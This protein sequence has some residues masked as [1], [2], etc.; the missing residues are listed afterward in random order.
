MYFILIKCLHETVIYIT[1]FDRFIKIYR[2]NEFK[3]MIAG[4]VTTGC[5]KKVKSTYIPENCEKRFCKSNANVFTENL[6]CVNCFQWLQQK[7]LKCMSSYVGILLKFISPHWL[8]LKNEINIKIVI[9]LVTVQNNRSSVQICF[10][11]DHFANSFQGEEKNFRVHFVKNNNVHPCYQHSYKLFT[12][13]FIWLGQKC[14]FNCSFYLI[15]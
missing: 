6:N 7:N 13:L 2:R 8:H 10:K 12:F 15:F 9:F 11:V 5:S 4:M 14:L 3:S 1:I